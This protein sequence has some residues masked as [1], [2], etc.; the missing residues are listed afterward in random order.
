MMISQTGRS[1]MAMSRNSGIRTR[2]QTTITVRYGY[3]SA[4]AVSSGP[5]TSQGR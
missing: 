4:S 2:S 3:R 1:A 5:P